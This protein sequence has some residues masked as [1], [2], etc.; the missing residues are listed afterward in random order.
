MA[1]SL[2][3]DKR[4]RT[5]SQHQCVIKIENGITHGLCHA[6]IDMQTIVANT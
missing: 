3:K 2:K 4:I 5:I 1:S 6:I